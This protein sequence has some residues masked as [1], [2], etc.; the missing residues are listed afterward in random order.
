MSGTIPD[1][2]RRRPL[3]DV[4]REE[5]RRQ[6]LDGTLAPGARLVE[7]RV[8]EVLGVS[9]NPVREALRALEAEGFVEIVPRRG[10]VVATYTEE[11]MED[12]YEVGLALETVAARLA[13]R[14]SDAAGA[15]K[16]RAVVADAALA[17]EA[18]DVA[19]I[20]R[21]NSLFH[22]IVVELANSSTLRGALNVV[23]GRHP[24]FV[25]V[26]P[27]ATARLEWLF[28]QKDGERA[29]DSVEEHRALANAIA[30]NDEELA[31]RLVGRHLEAARRSYREG[32]AG[33]AQRHDR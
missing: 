10:A 31:A 25:H 7:D 21:F 13:A 19:A 2:R 6:I 24:G 22:A 14:R 15:A 23:R 30:A 27:P 9:R 28:G 11:E 26:G 1:G 18:G 16:L 33:Q 8:A 17:V 4:V 3:R 29:V 20:A 32:G 5:L 12:A